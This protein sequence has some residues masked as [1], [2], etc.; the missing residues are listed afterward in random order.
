MRKLHIYFILTTLLSFENARSSTIIQ[1]QDEKSSRTIAPI[2]VSRQLLWTSFE[3][4]REFIINLTEDQEAT[5]IHSASSPT[6][7]AELFKSFHKSF[8]TLTESNH[9]LEEYKR[10]FLEARLLSGFLGKEIEK[11]EN[12]SCVK[13]LPYLSIAQ[14]LDLICPHVSK[15][16]HLLLENVFGLP[17]K[18]GTSNCYLRGM[19]NNEMQ[20]ALKQDPLYRKPEDLQ[21]YF[22][23]W[24]DTLESN[25]N[26]PSFQL[27]LLQQ[28]GPA[29]LPLRD[30][31]LY[32]P[33]LG[34]HEVTIKSDGT[35]DK[36]DGKYTY[37]FKKGKL[38][39]APNE[40]HHDE[41]LGPT[42]IECGGKIV[43][44]NKKISLITNRSGHYFPTPFHFFLILEQLKSRDVFADKAKLKFMFMN[45][46]RE[47][48]IPKSLPIKSLNVETLREQMLDEHYYADFEWNTVDNIYAARPKKSAS[49]REISQTVLHAESQMK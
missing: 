28:K 3:D 21:A 25:P 39:M 5:I 4:A 15:P 14:H 20:S 42:T 6:L 38:Y 10:A 19:Y 44:K 26:T 37:V 2:D 27:W 24:Q 23:K 17:P 33:L 8:K 12:A 32:P 36:A 9:S 49:A 18:P 41:V 22:S 31:S 47:R 35:I 16:T 43:L 30:K 13:A 48:S 1:A 34:L 29:A 46:K 40:L 11:V 45:Q 7:K